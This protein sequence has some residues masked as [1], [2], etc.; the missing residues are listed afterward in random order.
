M[1]NSLRVVCF[2][3]SDIH[4]R[5]RAEVPVQWL[6]F[7][8]QVGSLGALAIVDGALG[9]PQLNKQSGMSHDGRPRKKLQRNKNNS[10]RGQEDKNGIVQRHLCTSVRNN[11]HPVLAN[12]LTSCD[13]G[14]CYTRRFGN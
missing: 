5:H 14:C 8:A 3:M 9:G 2:G 11:R 1:S 10:L 6:D 13:V 7:R 4:E 12:N